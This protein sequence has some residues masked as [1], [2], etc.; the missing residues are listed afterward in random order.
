M[1]K[2]A[3]LVHNVSPCDIVKRV[4]DLLGLDLLALF[5][6]TKREQTPCPVKDICDAV[7]IA[8]VGDT[9]LHVRQ[10][11]KRKRQTTLDCAI[12]TYM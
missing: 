6:Y 7:C 3:L 11:S 12:V 5:G 2:N 9:N 1:R 4:Y 8:A 10:Q